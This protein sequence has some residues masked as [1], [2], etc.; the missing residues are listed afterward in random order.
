MPTKTSEEILAHGFLKGSCRVGRATRLDEK[1]R[2]ELAVNAHIR[3][4]YTD[5]D[6]YLKARR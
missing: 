3:H 5:Y 4:R 6:I 2:I 1:K